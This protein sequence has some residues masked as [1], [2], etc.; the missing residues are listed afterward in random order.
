MTKE[1]IGK[2][3]KER[4]NQLGMTQTDLGKKLGVGKSTIC[5]YEKGVLNNLTMGT[6]KKIAEAL[7]M[8]VTELFATDY[9]SLITSGD[10]YAD[11]ISSGVDPE[12]AKERIERRIRYYGEKIMRL[13][14]KQRDIVEDMI[15]ALLKKED[16]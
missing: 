5:K 1:D 15:D 14:Y 13:D 3:I 8:D 12:Q 16:D 2:K 7:R 10:D 11:L 9:R 4:R 6:Q